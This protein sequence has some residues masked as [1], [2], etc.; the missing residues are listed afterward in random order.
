MSGQNNE[1]D[2]NY[3]GEYNGKPIVYAEGLHDLFK[4]KA[5]LT[6]EDKELLAEHD[7]PLD[8]DVAKAALDEISVVP[9]NLA[10]MG[11]R[12][13]NLWVKLNKWR[14][15]IPEE[16]GPDTKVRFV[17]VHDND[18]EALKID[19]S[20]GQV[21]SDEGHYEIEGANFQR[22]VFPLVTFE[23][24]RFGGWASFDGARFGGLA[25]FRGGAL[26]VWQTSMG[27]ALKSLAHSIGWYFSLAPD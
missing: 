19:F 23:M 22:F 5:D 13:W 6:G 24:A 26:A 2:E 11:G 27:R 14:W 20:I 3:D 9:L 16:S 4:Q 8:L 18:Y 10:K 7:L 12:I 17:N 1:H 25:G 15:L 21:Q